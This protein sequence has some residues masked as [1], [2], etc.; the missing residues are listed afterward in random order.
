MGIVNPD[1]VNCSYLARIAKI[2]MG[3]G[4]NEKFNIRVRGVFWLEWL[5]T[6]YFFASS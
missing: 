2:A 3:K 1:V 6:L 4:V 5:F